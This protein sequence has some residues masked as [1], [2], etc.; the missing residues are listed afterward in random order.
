MLPEALLAHFMVLSLDELN[1]IMKILWR[2]VNR[3]A[4]MPVPGMFLKTHIT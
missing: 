4:F 1:K 2:P 3:P